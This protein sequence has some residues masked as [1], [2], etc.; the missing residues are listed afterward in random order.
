MALPFSNVAALDPPHMVATTVVIT[1]IANITFIIVLFI[2]TLVL[3]PSQVGKMLAWAQ[4]E[5]SQELP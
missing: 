1:V 3:F 4:K 2:F 5:D